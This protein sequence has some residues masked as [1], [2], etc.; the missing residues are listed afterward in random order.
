MNKSLQ[1]TMNYQLAITN[2]AA[3]GQSILANVWSIV[4]GQ[5]PTTAPKGDA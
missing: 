2:V 5:W 3:N 1:F 4:N